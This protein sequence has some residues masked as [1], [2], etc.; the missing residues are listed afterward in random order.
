[1]RRLFAF[2]LFAGLLA[3]AVPAQAQS[4]DD[5]PNRLSLDALTAGGG[6]SDSG[7]GYHRSHAR[8]YQPAHRAYRHYA[9]SR[10][11]VGR[12]YSNIRRSPPY[13][14]HVA[15]RRRATIHHARY[16]R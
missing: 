6:T 9:A 8:S 4:D 13:H 5:A 10:H 3:F 14:G 11:V 7:G 1:M 12:G 16:H 2:A 15:P